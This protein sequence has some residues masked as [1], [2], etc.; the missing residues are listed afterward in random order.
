VLDN[1]QNGG[2]VSV[3]VTGSI[4]NG[5]ISPQPTTDGFVALLDGA[6]GTL[7]V[8]VDVGAG[9]LQGIAVDPNS[10]TVFVAGTS[11]DPNTGAKNIMTAA[12]DTSLDP[13]PLYSATIP[14]QDAGGNNVNSFVRGAQSL[15]IDPQDN[16]YIMGTLMAPGSSDSSPVLV[17]YSGV[18]NKLLW[19]PIYFSNATYGGPGYGSAVV[20]QAF[21]LYVT[22]TVYNN[23]SSTP[24]NSD[25]ILARVPA[26]GGSPYFVYGWEVTDNGTRDGDWTGN[27]LVL[28]ANN[29]PIVAGGAV[30]PTGSSAFSPTKGVDVQVTHFGAS[31]STTA[32]G[33]YRPENT[34]GGSGTDMGNAVIP[35]PSNPGSVLVVGTTQQDP[36]NPD[37]D[38]FPTTANALQQ[39]YGGGL[40][41]GFLASVP[42]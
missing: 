21:S 39:I 29:E 13:T 3:Y 34:F 5:G 18:N 35:D 14:L 22:G 38:D 6:S 4:S 20:Y 16:V 8:P 27:G 31:G 33:T 7:L 30:D 19:Q 10:G 25:L 1:T 36:S 24:L 28:N 23:S 12:F 26:T 17:G 32:A 37:T 15:A 11:I 9:D 41:D 42:V 2:G 40:S